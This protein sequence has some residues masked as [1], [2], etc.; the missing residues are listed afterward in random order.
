MVDRDLKRQGLARRVVAGLPSF[1]AP[2]RLIRGS[3]LLLTCL[4]SV[5]EEAVSR[6]PELCLYP[7]PLA[8]PRISMM[9]IWHERTIAIGY[10]AGC[11]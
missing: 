7:L 11:V 9:Q 5:G 4:R 3:D 2:C 1:L 8:L 10:A 6:D